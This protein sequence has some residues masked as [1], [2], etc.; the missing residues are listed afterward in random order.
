M[1]AAG[2]SVTDAL[3]DGA[4]SCSDPEPSASFPKASGLSAGRRPCRSR[5]IPETKR[6]SRPAQCRAA[7]V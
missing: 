6:R 7:S 3:D 1:A 5:K 4:T 2:A